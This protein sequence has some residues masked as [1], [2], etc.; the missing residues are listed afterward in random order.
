M[1]IKAND[2]LTAKVVQELCF[3]SNRTA[4]RIINRYKAAKGL[5]SFTVITVDEFI[6][7]MGISKE[8]IIY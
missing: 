4:Y 2:K 5:P 8:R 7:Y 1:K 6:A 3:C